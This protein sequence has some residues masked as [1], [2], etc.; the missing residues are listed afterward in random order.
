ML[1]RKRTEPTWRQRLLFRQ[2]FRF[3]T[4]LSPADC[5]HRLHEIAALGTG[6]KSGDK[7]LFAVESPVDAVTYFSFGLQRDLSRQV[8]YTHIVGFGASAVDDVTG[9]TWVDC[10]VRFATP[11]L[12]SV[13][14]I[15]LG[16]IGLFIASRLDLMFLLFGLVISVAVT[17]HWVGLF[18]DR[19]RLLNLI[20]RALYV[21]PDAG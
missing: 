5:M 2:D 8:Y 3:W 9:A 17:M 16:A 1:K 18:L 20:Y 15:T 10:Q 11:Y 12:V 4:T 19:Q 7:L 6:L 14:V 13:V 21:E